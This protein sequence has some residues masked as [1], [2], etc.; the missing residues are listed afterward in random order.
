[1]A[2]LMCTSTVFPKRAST[3][4]PKGFGHFVSNAVFVLP[5]LILALIILLLTRTAANLAR[6][7]TEKIAN[8]SSES[9]SPQ[10]LLAHS[11]FAR[12]L[13]DML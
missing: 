4:N 6:S 3:S 11:S 5:A 12:C 1:M 9:L 10:T 7:A 2:I 13:L 8:R